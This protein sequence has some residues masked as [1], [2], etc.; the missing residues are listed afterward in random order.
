VSGKQNIT[1]T[2]DWRIPQYKAF[3]KYGGNKLINIGIDVHRRK[4]VATLKD[5]L[6]QIILQIIQQIIQQI[7][8]DNN[9]AGMIKFVN[10][11]KSRYGDA[12]VVC[13][14]TTN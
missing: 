1:M 9:S 7:T 10:N 11:L 2:M 5:S 12:R 8:F 3:P 6:L 4:C 14:S 13:E